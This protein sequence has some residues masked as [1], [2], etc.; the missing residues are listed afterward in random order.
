MAWV[1]WG[2]SFSWYEEAVK[3]YIEKYRDI[4]IKEMMQYRIPASITLAQ[5][6][7]ESDA[8]RSRLATEANN[9]FGIKCHKE[10]TGKSYI[11]DDET[12]NEC[13]RKY[14]NPEESFRD[15]SYF[16]SQRD[17]YKPLFSLEITDYKGW[18]NGLKTCGY[19]TNP[20]YAD[21][22][23]KTIEDYQLY[24][25]DVADFSIAFND[26]VVPS[27]DS[28]VRKVTAAKYDLFAE[29]PGKRMVY[30]NNG[31]QFIILRK[32]DNI[33]NVSKAFKVSE[34]KIRKFNEMQ[35]DAPLVPG[36][37]V[38]LEP[39]KKAGVLAM[40]VVK[41]G[42]TMYILSQN[43]GIQLSQLYK[44]NKLKPGRPIKQGQKILLR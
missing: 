35:K 16:L 22:L 30:L 15:H 39:K 12:K 4:A 5:G 42:E 44:I 17:R 9:H 8:G 43:Y 38:Y 14:S 20:Q 31:L 28:T 37:M 19:A 41:P 26:S 36:Q 23:I 40:H 6:I 34:R 21:H 1:P 27:G 24:R 7:Y 32:N 25:N 11:Q 3:A 18:A 2:S 10:W 29:G 33:K 13:F